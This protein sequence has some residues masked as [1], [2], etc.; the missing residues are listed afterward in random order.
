M[1]SFV[2]VKGN[3]REEA[4]IVGRL[5]AGYGELELS[6]CGCIAKIPGYDIHSGIKEIFGNKGAENRIKN[7]KKI[8][9]VPYTDAGLGAEFSETMSDMNWCREIR[10]QFAH[11]HWDDW[12]RRG[13]KFVDLEEVASMTG[14]VRKLA[15]AS[16]YVSL[17]ELREQEAFFRYVSTCFQ[18]LAHAYRCSVAGVT[19]RGLLRPAKMTRPPKH[20]PRPTNTRVRKRRLP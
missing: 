2:D 3:P 5:L 4:T 7:A 1:P 10:N 11:C 16:R 12:S 6:M 14:K 18:I 9:R 15:K 17:T 13:L 20:S 19:N 8:M